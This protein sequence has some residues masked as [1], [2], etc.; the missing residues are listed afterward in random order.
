MEYDEPYVINDRPFLQAPTV[1]VVEDQEEHLQY[2]H[3]QLQRLKYNVIATNDGDKALELSQIYEI[4]C[5]LLDIHL[6][7]DIS[8]I[9]I[10]EELRRNEKY[11]NIPIVSITAFFGYQHKK[12]FIDSGFSDYI[13]KPYNLEHLKEVL[14]KLIYKK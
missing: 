3:L 4:D 11:K 10:M 1:L 13:S 14:D 6:G 7:Q 8:G 2:L 5:I 9:S 12:D